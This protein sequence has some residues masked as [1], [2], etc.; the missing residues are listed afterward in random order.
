MFERL[1]GVFGKNKKIHKVHEEN[2]HIEG[3][4]DQNEQVF[5]PTVS[6]SE[7]RHYNKLLNLLSE[8]MIDIGKLRAEVT[9]IP[10]WAPEARSVSWK[11]LLG[12]SS[13]NQE[14]WATSLSRKREDYEECSRTHFPNLTYSEDIN[15]CNLISEEMSTYEEKNLK[16][17]LIDVKRTHPGEAFSSK[18]AKDML[19]RILFVWAFK[20]PASGYVQGI[21]DLAATFMYVFLAEAIDNN[22]REQG[23]IDDEENFEY[24]A[25]DI[26]L[27][28]MELLKEDQILNIEADTFGCLENFL[29]TLQEN[30]TDKQ[31][32][33]H[34]IMEKVEQIIRK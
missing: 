31:P 13:P 22:K 23:I 25:Y 16:Q 12:Y 33:V 9:Y 17:I 30:Y 28:D 11:L 3:E 2:K 7:K 29:E 4:G 15:E 27:E 1:K 32:G 21:N 19:T 5:I 20:H 14:L 8:P 24:N 18:T 10:L 34:K 26:K 6:S